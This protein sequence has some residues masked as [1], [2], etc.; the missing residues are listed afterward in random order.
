M[1]FNVD[2]GNELLIKLLENTPNYNP[3]IFYD[4]FIPFKIKYETEERMRKYLEK[5]GEYNFL[6]KDIVWTREEKVHSKNKIV[7]Y[8]RNVLGWNS[9]YFF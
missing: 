2:T 4:E 7:E 8:E 9:K 1:V 5:S 6:N 3:G